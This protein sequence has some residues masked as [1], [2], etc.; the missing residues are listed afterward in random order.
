M[1]WESA[2]TAPPSLSALRGVLSPLLAHGALLCAQQ[3][4]LRR[5]LM[6]QDCLSTLRGRLRG[7]GRSLD[8]AKVC[9]YGFA[10]LLTGEGGSS[11]DPDHT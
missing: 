4:S 9:Q 6:P 2:C 8:L 5:Q 1:W 10:G 11:L 3:F 7:S